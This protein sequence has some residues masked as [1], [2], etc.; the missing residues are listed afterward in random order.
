M[1]K[2]TPVTRPAMLD[3]FECKKWVE[4]KLGYDIRDTL[5]KFDPENDDRRGEI[6]Y[7]DWWHLLCTIQNP[8]NGSDIWIGSEMLGEQPWQDEITKCFIDEFGDDQ[9]YWV[10]W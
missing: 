9:T 6:E 10:E 8:H 5:G 3:F 7:R 2:P 4:K 1:D